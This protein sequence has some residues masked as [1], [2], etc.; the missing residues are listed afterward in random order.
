MRHMTAVASLTDALPPRF[1]RDAFLPIAA[2]V[3]GATLPADWITI[4]FVVFGQAHF[5]M[6]FLYQYRGGKMTRRYLAIAAVLAAAAAT[7]MLLSREAVL[8]IF[9]VVATLFAAH[10]AFDEF[11]LRGERATL[12]GAATAW[13]FVL[14]FVGMMLALAFPD[15]RAFGALAGALALSAG[16]WGAVR[17]VR[18]SLSGTERYLLLV[19]AVLVALGMGFGFLHQVLAVVIIL[20]CANWMLGYGDRVRSDTRRRRKY[21]IETAL[22]LGGASA[23]YAAFHFFGIDALRYFFLLAYYDAWAIGHIALSFRGKAG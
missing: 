21:W 7:Y 23:L 5:A 9:L 3:L 16:A 18:G 17:L 8:P 1:F 20:H 6:T 2:L 13:A 22:T 15:I 11:H 4:A 14:V 10:F 12:H 19:G